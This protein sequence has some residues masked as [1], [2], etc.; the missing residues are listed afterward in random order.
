MT[1]QMLRTSTQ[2]SCAVSGNQTTRVLCSKPPRCPSSP[3]HTNTK[4][5]FLTIFPGHYTGRTYHT[6]LIA[7]QGGFANL[8]ATFSGGNV[9]HVG[10]LFYDTA[11]QEA[12]GVVEPYASNTQDLTS[13]DDDALAPDAAGDDFDPFVQYVYLGDTV[14]DGVLGWISIGMDTSQT[15]DVSSAATLTENGGVVNSDFSAGGGGDGQGMNGTGGPSGSAPS[16][17]SPSATASLTCKFTPCS[18][19]EERF[20]DHEAGF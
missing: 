6:H 4:K 19:S 18:S 20:A 16:G 11:L 17:A 5:R 10:Q 2:R 3:Y 9:T 1:P 8:N 12:V 13:N 7:H 14:E 15:Y